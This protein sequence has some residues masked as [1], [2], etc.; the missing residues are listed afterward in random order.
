MASS[1][2]ICSKRRSSAP[3]RTAGGKWLGEIGSLDVVNFLSWRYRDPERQLAD[4]LGIKPAHAYYGPVGGESPI[5]YLHEAAQRIARG[6]CSVAAVCG[7][8]AQSTATKAERAGITCRGRRSRTTSRSPN[9]A[10]R[11]RS[12]SRCKLGVFRPV[13]SIRSTK[14]QARRIGARPRARRWRNPVTSMVEIFRRRVAKSQ[15]LAEAA[16]L[17]PRRSRRRRPTTG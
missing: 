8:E 11:S 15:R 7:A 5:R 6:E 17:H 9:A 10:P 3:K 1:R 12:R 4:R 16:F 13:R 14:P 2:S